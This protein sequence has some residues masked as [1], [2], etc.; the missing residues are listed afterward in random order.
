GHAD[1]DGIVPLNAIA[2]EASAADRLRVLL[3]D[4]YEAEWSAAKLQELLGEWSSLEEWLRD[5]FFEEHC[6]IFQQRPFIW[7]IWD[8]RKDGFHALVNYHVLSAPNGEARNT[9]E[10]LIYTYL[11]R[12]IDR[13]TDEVR[14]GK[15]GADARLT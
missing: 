10:K 2:G 11:G 15:E 4:A 8:G 14:N 1:A 5:G 7:H 6:R 13:Q 3:A 12:W 9:I